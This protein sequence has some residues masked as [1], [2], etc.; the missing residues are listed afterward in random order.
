MS[1]ENRRISD[2]GISIILVSYCV[3]QESRGCR[4]ESRSLLWGEG[5]SRLLGPAK[6]APGADNPRY[7]ADKIRSL[8]T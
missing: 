5:I 4:F 7:A 2:A 1:E 8:S 3:R 6:S